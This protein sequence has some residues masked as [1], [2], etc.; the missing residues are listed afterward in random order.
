MVLA[1]G[2]HQLCRRLLLP[3]SRSLLLVSASPLV[4]SI[5]VSCGFHASE[6]QAI[7]STVTGTLSG[8]SGTLWDV[9]NFRWP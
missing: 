1:L 9:V 8:F 4:N 6:T 5:P 7:M 3:Q 2:S